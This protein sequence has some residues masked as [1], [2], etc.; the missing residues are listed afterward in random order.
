MLNEERIRMMFQI[1]KYEQGIGNR[2][3]RICKY[4]EKDYVAFSLIKNFF[5]ATITYF[6][7]LAVVVFCNLS[8]WLNLLSETNLLALLIGALIGYLVVLAVYSVLVYTI[9]RLRYGRARRRVKYYYDML[10]KLQTLY[11]DEARLAGGI[12]ESDI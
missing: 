9:S 8:Y 11:R 4:T 1:A 6:L 5:F 12:Y 10:K 2:D 7:L 3:I